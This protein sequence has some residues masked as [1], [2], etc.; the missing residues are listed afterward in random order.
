LF[1]TLFGM[2]NFNELKKFLP[3]NSNAISLTNKDS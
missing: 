2:M 1:E 3:M